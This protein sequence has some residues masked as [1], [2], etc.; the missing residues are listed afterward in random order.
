MLVKNWFTIARVCLCG[1]IYF[2]ITVVLIVIVIVVFCRDAT[3]YRY[4]FF[5]V[6]S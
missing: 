2:V 5:N 1:C 3:F 6:D 4:F